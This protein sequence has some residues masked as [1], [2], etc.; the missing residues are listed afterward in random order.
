MELQLEEEQKWLKLI[1]FKGKYGWDDEVIGARPYPWLQVTKCVCEDDFENGVGA[2][3]LFV[4]VG[5][6]DGA[7]FIPLGH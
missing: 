6:R 4:H 1:C 5:G 7:G 3:A 2:T